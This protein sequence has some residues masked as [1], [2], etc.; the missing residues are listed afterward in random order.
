MKQN[1]R[2]TK[3]NFCETKRNFASIFEVRNEMKFRIFLF[4]E[5]SEIFAKQATLSYRFVFRKI[6]KK[7]KLKTLL[8]TTCEEFV[9]EIC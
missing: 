8:E 7:R 4:R 9:G 2:E 3:L 5:T 1:F 6:K